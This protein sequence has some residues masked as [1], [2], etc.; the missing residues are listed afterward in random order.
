VPP[1]SRDR[2][3]CGSVGLARACRRNA[4]RILPSCTGIASCCMPEA[5][6]DPAVWSVP[7]AHVSI[8]RLTST[9]RRKWSVA[10]SSRRT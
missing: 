8:D 10:G 6:R 1:P 2:G 3:T 5:G 9:E 7:C 4:R